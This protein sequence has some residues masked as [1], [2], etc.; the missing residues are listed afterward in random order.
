M[1]SSGKG[2]AAVYDLPGRNVEL[3]INWLQ[4]G[5]PRLQGYWR[6]HSAQIRAVVRRISVK[7][8][9]LWCFMHAVHR[10]ANGAPQSNDPRK[11]DAD[12]VGLAPETLRLKIIELSEVGIIKLAQAASGRRSATYVLSESECRSVSTRSTRHLPATPMGG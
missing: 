5:D 1:G 11:F 3:P 10:Q 9:K 4:Q 2:K 6:I 8:L 7:A 12:A